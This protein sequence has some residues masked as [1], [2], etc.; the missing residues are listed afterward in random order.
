[1]DA[2]PL[3]F[4]ID[5]AVVGVPNLVMGAV[6]DENVRP[7]TLRLGRVDVDELGHAVHMWIGEYATT[8]FYEP[9]SCLIV[10]R[11]QEG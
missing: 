7:P 3:V 9:P 8:N 2:N 5:S 6:V 10:V 1:M 4:A 11:T